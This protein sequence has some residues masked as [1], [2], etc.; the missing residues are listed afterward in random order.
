M[1]NAAPLIA[2]VGSVVVVPTVAAYVALRV[3]S[4]QLKT[5]RRIARTSAVRDVLDEG[6]EL[7]LSTLNEDLLQPAPEG[8]IEDYWLWVHKLKMEG[9]EARLRLWF[10]ADHPVVA[11]WRPLWGTTV[12]TF[13]KASVSSDPDENPLVIHER[14]VDEWL[15]AARAELD[16]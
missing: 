11:A 13:T 8:A 4:E 1:S 6:A 3:H 12:D 2:A 9:Y 7:L 10:N 5:N 14:A 15:R 16:I